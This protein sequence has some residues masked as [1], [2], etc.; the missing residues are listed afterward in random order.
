MAIDSKNAGAHS[1]KSTL[2]T[3]F[4]QHEEA[5]HEME[6]ACRYD[7]ESAGSRS[8]LAWT[9]YCSRRYDEAIEQSKKALGIDPSSDVTHRQLSKEYLLK[10]RLA[11]AL[12]EYYK[13]RA[14]LGQPTSGS[15]GDLGLIRAAE[16][17]LDD[18]RSILRQME[19][20]SSN[21]ISNYEYV[22]AKLH[23]SLKE[24]DAAFELLS[25]ACD[26]HLARAIWIRAD[27]EL[28]PIHSDPRFNALLKR[29]HLLP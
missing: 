26:R 15:I 17:Q 27:P 8:D 10:G 9:L 4:V 6:L 7:P 5:I 25:K 19:M 12:S 16:G 2:L 13:T 22:L 23:V 20:R 28:D 3:A 1:A 11:D 29:V 18:T 14:S 24:P 21:E